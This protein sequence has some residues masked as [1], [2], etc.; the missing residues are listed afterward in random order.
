MKNWRTEDNLQTIEMSERA[1]E[2]D[3]IQYQAEHLI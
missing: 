3:Q 1:F 2:S